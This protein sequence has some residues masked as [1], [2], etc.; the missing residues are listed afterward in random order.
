[1]H[2]NLE[3]T[4]AGPTGLSSVT[5]D[6]NSSA[7]LV[8]NLT[9]QINQS[10]DVNLSY[11]DAI[12][13]TTEMR[14][15]TVP[16]GRTSQSFQIFVGDDDIAAQST[17]VFSVTVEPGYGYVV[18]KP[19][20]VAVSVLDNDTATVSISPVRDT[21]TEGEDA[22]F[23]VML[24]IKT[25]VAASVGVEFE[26]IGDD[27]SVAAMNLDFVV[28]TFDEGATSTEVI[29]PTN[30]NHN[31][32]M[33]SS[34]SATLTNEINSPLLISSTQRSATIMILDGTPVV[35]VTTLDGDDSIQVLESTGRVTLQLNINP[36]FN[37]ALDVNVLYSGDPGA[38]TGAFT[39]S[40]QNM[41]TVTVSTNVATQTFDVEVIDDQIAE[42]IRRVNVSVIAGLNYKV[43]ASSSVEIAVVDDDVATVSISP[44]RDT[45][46]E[47]D[48]IV[49]TVTRDLAAAQAT[50]I[51]LTLTYNG[52]FF[53]TAGNTLNLD[54][55]DGIHLNL[56]GRH[57]RNGKVYYY[58]DHSGDSNPDNL[59][60][61][62]HILLDNLLNDG[63]DT[64]NTQPNGHDGSNDERSVIIDGYALV[65]PTAAEIQ[66][67]LTA[68]NNEV[69]DGW[70]NGE[71]YWAAG[72]FN[73]ADTR[74][75]HESVEVP[76]GDVSDAV[77]STARYVFF[78]VLTAQRTTIVNLPAEPMGTVMVEVATIDMD[79]SITDGSLIAELEL[80][81]QDDS[82]IKL[83]STVSEVAILH[84]N[85]V[86]TITGPT[87]LS[88]VTVDE[89]SSVTLVLN[90]MP[91]ID[92][93]RDVNLSYVGIISGTTET[94]TIRVPAG[95]TSHRFSI[96]VGGDDIAAQSTRAFNVTVEPSPGYV[97]GTSSS[98]AVSV[99]NDDPA[100][101]SVFA[102]S[103]IVYEG[104]TALFRVQVSNEIATSLTVII[105]LTTI[106]NFGI[107]PGS[108][109]LVITAGNT[110]ASLTFMTDD[111]E[112]GEAYGSL[113]ATIDSPLALPESISGVKPT[114]STTNSSATVTILDDDLDLSVSITTLD[115]NTSTT[116][117]ESDEVML[118]LMLSDAIN[119]SLRVNLS[120][121]RDTKI[122]GVDSPSF[123]DVPAEMTTHNFTVFVINDTI[124]AQPERNIDISVVA[125]VGYTASTVPV[126]VKVIDDDTATVTIS[127]VRGVITG[128]DDAVFKV[129]LGLVT[130][131]DVEIGIDVGSGGNFITDEDRGRTT[132][133]VLAGQISTVLTVQTM[134]NTGREENSTLVATLMAIPHLDLTIGDPSSATVVIKALS[135]LSIVAMPASVSLVEG[136]ASTQISVSLNRIREGEGE[137]AVT[138]KPEGIGLTVSSPVLTFRSTEL[139]TVTVT[140]TSNGRYTGDR[141]ATLTFTA[142]DYATAM[143]TVDIIEDTPQPIRL[144]VGS[145]ELSLVRFAST[146]ITVSVD[147]A[148]DLTVKA[149]GAV[150]LEVRCAIGIQI[151]RRRTITADTD[152]SSQRRRGNHYVHG[153]RSQAVNSDGDSESNGK[154]TGISD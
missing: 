14:T 135:P 146:E 24:D 116:V 145:T 75:F 32:V 153:Q 96:L 110:T 89:N 120:Y 152:R 16:A 10:R 31:L 56:T 113:I 60:Q 102:V 93:S 141:S 143:V 40:V 136:G 90:V 83:G 151:N 37:R 55:G 9:P 70:A 104:E 133:T 137:I 118:R 71:F 130:A 79:D 99:L 148:T 127:P 92:Q 80:I 34:L 33:D 111:D 140:A 28:V 64:I 124:V 6:E 150:S 5:V 36:T 94:T 134:E 100:V 21:I 117:S 42:F 11:M 17:R 7:T 76:G 44:V 126:T 97:V 105:D 20:S 115:E 59:D 78:Q 27:E 132:V 25:A 62:T 123:V 82:P 81:E 88:S 87:G 121:A 4:I 103:D 109:N 98:V 84:N 50:S 52:D 8:L 35:G 106:G 3:V 125:G 13:G 108:T 139:R 39:D 68:G 29:V 128:G 66:A 74:E 18:G 2:N 77:D 12:F 49:F 48:T 38:L 58:L 154:H 147:V 57:K 101:V 30:N 107:S 22:V 41:S 138:I 114:I 142:S 86:I 53:S 122:L 131:V 46:T 47:G 26:F 19:S 63:A 23:K 119:R 91:Q 65:L 73:V 45:V 144:E 95:S 85:A 72:P 67:F 112:T 1:M 43:A 51:S 129:M 54:N 15:I 149:E 61:I 69:P